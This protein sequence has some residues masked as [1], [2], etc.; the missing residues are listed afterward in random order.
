MKERSKIGRPTRGADSYQ[1]PSG[2]IDILGSGGGRRTG[3]EDFILGRSSPSG[4]NGKKKKN[5]G[6]WII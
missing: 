3:G 1:P 5:N 4:K 6:N 2:S